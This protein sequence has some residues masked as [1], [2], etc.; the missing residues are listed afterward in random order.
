MKFISLFF[1]ALLFF[2]PVMASAQE[3]GNDA[4]ASVSADAATAMAPDELVKN[5]TNE[6]LEVVR[7]DQD[8][9]AGD[10]RK[11]IVLVEEKVLPHFDFLRMTRLAMG[12][13]WRKA[14]EAQQQALADEFRTLL[15]RTYS[16]A[17]NEYKTQTISFKPLKTK[18]GATDVKVATQ[19]NQTGSVKPITLDYYLAK[20]GASWKVYDIEVGGISLVTNYRDFFA[21]E[22]RKGEVDGLIQS[23][24]DK[25]LSSEQAASGKP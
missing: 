17:L 19:I 20:Q 15:V 4:G 21:S 2:T 24:R 13:N 3:A 5:V 7:K 1:A 12:R 10:T 9:Q 22:I 18:P 6:V 25:N 14:S 11:A 8:I 16:K 23:L